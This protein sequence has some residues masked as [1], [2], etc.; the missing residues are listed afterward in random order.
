MAELSNVDIYIIDNIKAI[1]IFLPSL[2]E[3]GTKTEKYSFVI[4]P[5]LFRRNSKRKY[6]LLR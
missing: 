6:A 2:G 5:A 1:F 3:L 4:E